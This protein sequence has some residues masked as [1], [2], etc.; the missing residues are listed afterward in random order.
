MTIR[1][2]G[3]LEWIADFTRLY[4][5][6]PFRC[7]AAKIRHLEI[8]FCDAG[9]ETT[10]ANNDLEN[11]FAEKL[12]T[13]LLETVC[14][15]TSLT[16]E[17]GAVTNDALLD[18][19]SFLLHLEV[20]NIL[21][22]GVYVEY[23]KELGNPWERCVSLRT[24]S[25]ESTDD[26]GSSL[27][28]WIQIFGNRLRTLSITGSGAYTTRID[29][30]MEVLRFPCLRHL[31]ITF[32]SFRQN[33]WQIFSSSRLTYLCINNK[34]QLGRRDAY[35]DLAVTEHYLDIPEVAKL[36]E[37]L[38]DLEQ[39]GSQRQT[40]AHKLVEDFCKLRNLSYRYKTLTLVSTWSSNLMNQ[41]TVCDHYLQ[42]WEQDMRPVLAYASRMVNKV[43][44]EGDMQGSKEVG[45]ALRHLRDLKIRDEE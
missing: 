24:L 31:S 33:M 32:R 28:D 11:S 45:E 25:V 8:K 18:G 38:E 22:A 29:N 1:I 35:Q 9:D 30:D 5:Y 37:G 15:I 27:L 10:G 43:A 21:A 3:C 12:L 2:E 17:I 4:H 36:W 16:L 14:F 41:P 7:V 13:Q 23:F 42:D 20:L 26:V 40:Q 44:L 19:F 6:H 34:L 39:L